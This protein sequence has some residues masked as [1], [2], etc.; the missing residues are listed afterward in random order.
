MIR[1]ISLALIT[2][3][4]ISCS[5]SPTALDKLQEC[6]VESELIVVH[7][8]GHGWSGKEFTPNKEQIDQLTYEAVLKILETIN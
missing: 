7:G 4:I 5:Q 6:G 2:S 8:A 3:S 1:L